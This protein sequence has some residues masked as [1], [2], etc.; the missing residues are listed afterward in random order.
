[1]NEP[2]NTVCPSSTCRPG[3]KLFGIVLPDGHVALTSECIEVDREFAQIAHEG[4]PPEQRF[5]FASGCMEGACRQWTGKQC[6][7]IDRLVAEHER[8]L[9]EVIPPVSLPECPIRPECRWY[10]QRGAQACSVCSLVV[11]DMA[12][13][14][15]ALPREVALR[16]AH[17]R[18][19][20][21]IS[22]EKSTPILLQKA[23]G[24]Q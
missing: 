1:M 7:L 5:R 4:R 24:S 15:A 11:T 17:Y 20:T 16:R 19:R 13:S 8:Q 18:E 23:G 21:R 9:G 14:D 2:P 3:A 12:L 6:G 22:S 10:S